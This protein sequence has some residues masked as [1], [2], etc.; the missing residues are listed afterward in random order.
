MANAK[1]KNYTV[2]DLTLRVNVEFG[3]EYGSDPEEV[4]KVVLEAIKG[5]ENVLEAPAPV[6]SFIKMSDFSL[7]FIART[8]VENYGDAYST[9]LLMIDVI[10]YSL[11]KAGIG[12]PFPTQTIYTKSEDGDKNAR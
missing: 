9:K 4:R 6:V 7:D 11:N 8:W 12:I 2:P 10:Y 1:I 5:I 3:V